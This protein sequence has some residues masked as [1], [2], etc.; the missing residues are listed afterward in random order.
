MSDR[1]DLLSFLRKLKPIQNLKTPL[2]RIGP[3]GDGGYL[4]P[5]DLHGI[6]A[7]FS[8]GVG[9]STEFERDLCN[10]GIRCFLADGSVTKPAAEHSLIHFD[11]VYISTQ[12]QPSLSLEE[13]VNSKQLPDGDHP[14]PD[15]HRRLRVGCTN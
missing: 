1:G 11:K 6:K 5:D 10:M 8:P 2:V 13:W 7:C 12:L 3:K 4:L 9:N 15:G 14:S